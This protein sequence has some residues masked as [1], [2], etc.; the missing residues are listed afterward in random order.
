M[1]QDASL[2]ELV[3]TKEL[4]LKEKESKVKEEV[5]ELLS[6]TRA[7]ADSLVQSARQ[8]GKVKAEEYY[9]KETALLGSEK[10]RI[11]SEASA[12]REAIRAKGRA[13]IRE[14]VRSITERVAFS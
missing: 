9:K 4:E 3:K 5:E 6:R 13:R 7:E 1:E 10:E 14:A 11:R 8:E 12:R 2:L